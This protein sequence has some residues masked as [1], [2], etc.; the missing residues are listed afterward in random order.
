MTE[1]ERQDY[2]KLNHEGKEAYDRDV[3]NILIVLIVS[4]Y[5]K[6]NGDYYK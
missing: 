5:L 2:N 1:K 3:Q 4:T 6:P